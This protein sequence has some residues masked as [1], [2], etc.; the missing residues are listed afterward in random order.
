MLEG[1]GEERFG[2][3]A[4]RAGPQLDVPTTHIKPLG[5]RLQT[6]LPQ[7]W[8]TDP[9]C[10]H[11]SMRRTTALALVV[12]G[13][14][15]AGFIFSSSA[16]QFDED[17]APAAPSVAAGPQTKM[18]WWREKFGPAGQQLVFEVERFQ[19]VENGWRASVV[20]TNNTSVAYELG[21]PRAT[22]DRSFGLMLFET[23][24]AEELERRNGDG[25]LPAIRPAKRYEPSLPKLLEPNATWRGVISA[26][27]SLVAGTFV[28]VV[29][30][31]LVAIGSTGDI[32]EERVVW[33][34]DRAYHLQR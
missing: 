29:F 15:L 28:R 6:G 22:I 7:P 3:D 25:S 4:P 14:A 21:D 1:I 24:D 32:L 17:E 10:E 26:P 27:G 16:L 18:L 8:A 19:V 11:E 2:R 20:V 31:A 34:T 30:G 33:I 23:G 12:L 9:I 5:L 13:A